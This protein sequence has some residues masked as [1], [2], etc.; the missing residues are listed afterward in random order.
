MFVSSSRVDLILFF[1]SFKKHGGC[2]LPWVAPGVA[3]KEVQEMASAS[4]KQQGLGS[5]HLA[6]LG[7]K[8]AME[9]L[10][11]LKT[12]RPLELNPSRKLCLLEP[13]PTC[14]VWTDGK[15]D[16]DLLGERPGT[17]TC[18]DSGGGGGHRVCGGNVKASDKVTG[19]RRL[20]ALPI[21]AK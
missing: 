10:W 11:V 18:V 7:E 1:H 16:A 20:R 5:G 19:F 9:V 17:C 12:G 8:P 15:E 3:A 2:T 13:R 14:G 6:K 4:E 21:W